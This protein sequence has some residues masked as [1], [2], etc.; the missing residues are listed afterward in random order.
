MR[1]L[2]KDNFLLYAAANYV[3]LECYSTEEL[4]DDLNTFTY[5]KKLFTRYKD[6]GD[7]KERL[8]VNHL[9]KLFN[10]F[11]NEA[12]TRMLFFKIN[13]E[14]WHYLKSFLLYMG[15][16]PD[17]LYHIEEKGRHIVSADIPIDIYIINKLRKL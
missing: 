1:V 4:Y 6:S 13:K 11:N 10:I 17:V 15:H 2:S 16:M 7:L 12:A 9:I 3:N 5:L 14:H 8:I